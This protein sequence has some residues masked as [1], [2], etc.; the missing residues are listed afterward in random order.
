M[1]LVNF[2]ELASEFA[3]EFPK[4]KDIVTE[5]DESER[6]AIAYVQHSRNFL[7]MLALD[8]DDVYE[9]TFGKP[10]PEDLLRDASMAVAIGD[11]EDKILAVLVLEFVWSFDEDSRLGARVVAQCVRPEYKGFGLNKL[12]F[13]AAEVFIG[14]FVADK[15]FDERHELSRMFEQLE[16]DERR[17]FLVA[18]CAVSSK[19]RLLSLPKHGFSKTDSDW[20]QEKEE[21]IFERELHLLPPDDASESSEAF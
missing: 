2:S 15:C 17:M 3:E 21:V 13:N 9:A 6:K 5:L 4:Y 16:S 11:K 12:L 10:V 18:P 20:R 19:K 14:C 1:R 8:L 7:G